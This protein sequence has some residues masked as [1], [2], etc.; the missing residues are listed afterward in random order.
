[1]LAEIYRDLIECIESLDVLDDATRQTIVEAMRSRARAN[2][3]KAF[4]VED[5]IG[6][7][8]HL[9]ELGE[10][11][12]TIVLRL[13]AAHEIGQSQAYADLKRAKQIFQ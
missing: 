7:A 5:R 2:G 9:L 3:V 11:D 6:F 13:M 4:V 12:Q 8:V 1:M 10:D